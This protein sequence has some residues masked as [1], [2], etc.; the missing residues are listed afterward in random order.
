V[1]CADP[2]VAAARDVDAAELLLTWH[3]QRNGKWRTPTG[4]AWM[5]ALMLESLLASYQR[6]QSEHY[7]RVVERSFERHRGRRSRYYDDNGWYANVWI[8]AYDA[9]G[10][11]PFLHEARA[12]FGDLTAGWDD[13]CGGG[14]WWR[15]KPDYK[16]AITNS[17]FLRA[18]AR[19]HRRQPD[20]GYDEWAARATHWID[21][22]GLIASSS[23]VVDGLDA[24]CVPTGPAWTYNQGALILAFVDWSS[25]S[26]DARLLTKS[27]AM[28]DAT[29]ATLVTRDGILQ[30]HCEPH[31]NCDGD[32]RILKG[33]F[34]H[35][36]GALYDATGDASYRDF[37]IRNADVV[38]DNARTSDGVIGLHWSGPPGTADAATHASGALLFSTV[39]RLTA[40]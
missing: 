30:E 17:L 23:L 34:A 9:T 26:A 22:S 10:R 14:L 20:A 27:R 29:I 39:A 21:A 12:I 1:T 7:L 25:A 15:T 35:A 16:N 36:L 18:A 8:T 3:R 5:P 32:Q 40:H 31:G 11:T 33:V 4:E 38:W 2:T 6:T 13:H 19:L 24:M 37:L 28:A